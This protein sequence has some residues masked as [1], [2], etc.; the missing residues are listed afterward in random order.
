M[1]HLTQNQP[2]TPPA[3]AWAQ[4]VGRKLL[5]NGPGSGGSRDDTA[6]TRHCGQRGRDNKEEPPRPRS[7]KGRRGTPDAPGCSLHHPGEAQA[8]PTG[9]WRRPASAHL[10]RSFCSAEQH[11]A[12]RAGQ[13]EGVQAGPG[14]GR[15]AGPS[16]RGPT[17]APPKRQASEV[18]ARVCTSSRSPR[19]TWP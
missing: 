14:P 16:G 13:G 10:Q 15:A 12:G 3:A 19:E 7:A 2:A 17:G 5:S 11:A 9:G 6:F 1:H 18:E 4:E 8:F